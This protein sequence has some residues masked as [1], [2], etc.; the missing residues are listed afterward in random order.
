MRSNSA[1]YKG[2]FAGYGPHS[3]RSSRPR[4]RRRPWSW[5]GGRYGW[6]G[7][8]RA[9]SRPGTARKSPGYAWCAGAK[10]VLPAA[11]TRAPWAG[12]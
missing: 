2:R 8:G 7:G 11:P 12:S 6:C 3:C 4:R 10:R 1:A 9:L 5:A